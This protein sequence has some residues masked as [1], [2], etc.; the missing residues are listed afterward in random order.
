MMFAKS[1]GL[2]GKNRTRFN[3]CVGSE[4]IVQKF[5]FEAFEKNKIN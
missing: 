2:L 3:L 4:F 5:A 1:K